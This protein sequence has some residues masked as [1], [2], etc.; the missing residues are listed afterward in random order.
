MV[1]FLEAHHESLDSDMDMFDLAI[2]Y[3]VFSAELE[4]T[5]RHSMVR[6][7]SEVVKH[8][9]RVLVCQVSSNQE[10]ARSILVDV[11]PDPGRVQPC[12]TNLSWTSHCSLK[13]A[14]YETA[15]TESCPVGRDHSTLAQ[16]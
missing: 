2:A 3:G 8:R 13:G 10:C 5:E 12:N 7:S 1:P 14:T 6:P 15:C 16:A 4:H 11:M 9:S